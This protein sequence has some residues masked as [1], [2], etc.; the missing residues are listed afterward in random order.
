[1]SIQTMSGERV[2]IRS[3]TN[4]VQS[5][6][7]GLDGDFTDGIEFADDRLKEI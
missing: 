6:K 4:Q 3:E 1:M 5:A 2:N 7:G